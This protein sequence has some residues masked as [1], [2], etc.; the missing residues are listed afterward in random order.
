MLSLTVFSVFIN[1][2]KATKANP[3]SHTQIFN[4][5]FI[6]LQDSNLVV[7]LSINE[8]FKNY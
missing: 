7:E 3:A 6:D 4:F 8:V 1:A 5:F 2:L